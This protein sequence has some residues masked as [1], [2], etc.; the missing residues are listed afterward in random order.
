MGGSIKESVLLDAAARVSSAT[1]G[2]SRGPG[3]V[4]PHDE[5]WTKL[6]GKMARALVA[7]PDLVMYFAY[8]VSNRACALAQ[9]AAAQLSS[10]AVSVEG[11]KYELLVPKSPTKLQKAVSLVVSRNSY[12]TAD[13]TR[14]SAEVDSYVSSELIPKITKS[15]RL[16]VRGAEA[17]TEYRKKRDE[18]IGTWKKLQQALSDVSSTRYFTEAPLR[19]VALSVPL[20]A[21]NATA[22]LLD[23]TNL[24][25]Y[26]VQLVAAGAA[27]A[28][29]GRRVDLKTR[30]RTGVDEFPGGVAA[31][32]VSSAGVVVEVLM[33][34]SPL[35]LCIRVGDSVISADQQTAT[36]QAVSETGFTLANSTI[37]TITAGLSVVSTAYVQWEALA[38]AM[39]P[40]YVAMPTST[41]MLAEVRRQESASAARIRGLMEFLCRNAVILDVASADALSAL[42][43]VEGDLY[44]Y[45]ET[46]V[47]AL[48]RGF[49]P[50]FTE[51]T[52]QA[53]NRLLSELES[54]GFDY[55]VELL[56]RGEVDLLMQLDAASVSRA[57]RMDG[58]IA[59]LGTYAGGSRGVG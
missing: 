3:G 53:G 13:V 36:V 30:V 58:A 56:Y 25:A 34:P 8:L 49:A 38:D 9:K 40:P 55:A 24:T 26:T 48:L 22:S 6:R 2:T 29:M 11:W 54:G 43:R 39:I 46:P 15:G 57:G 51:K 52:K 7:D 35:L 20:S 45:P 21:L 47:A 41:A 42:T 14:L 27:V 31:T 12:S 33:T 4:R 37:T 44:V 28:S 5:E 10:M 19:N 50:A 23:P 32:G 18:L 59:D 1:V 16:Q 17:Y